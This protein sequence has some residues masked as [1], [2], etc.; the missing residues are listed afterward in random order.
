ML[1]QTPLYHLL[2]A[3]IFG[4]SLDQ[5]SYI[6]SSPNS[7][8]NNASSNN[9]IVSIHAYIGTPPALHAPSQLKWRLGPTHLMEDPL[10][11]STIATIYQLGPSYV[12]SFLAPKQDGEY[13][14]FHSP[15]C[16]VAT[17]QPSGKNDTCNKYL[18]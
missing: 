3:V 16:M 13:L 2:T 17:Q 12:G 1:C 9:H 10:S 7:S 15:K 14:L 18:T 4:L 5:I 11:S 6:N 8:G